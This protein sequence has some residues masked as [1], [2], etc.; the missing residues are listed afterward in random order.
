MALVAETGQG[1]IASPGQLECHYAPRAKLRLNADSVEAA[2]RTLPDPS[3]ARLRSL[4]D[5]LTM[6]K[7][8]DGQLNDSPLTL[9]DLAK[10]KEGFVRVLT[11]IFH[12]R[13][14]YP[15]ELGGGGT[16]TQPPAENG[17]A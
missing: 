14:K 2:S 11:A 16:G 1:K 13:V 9:T 7:L 10:A 17:Q 3:P 8:L 5:E 4:V 12:S 15:G 6:R